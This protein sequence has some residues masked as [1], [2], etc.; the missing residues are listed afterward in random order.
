LSDLP[1][2]L[3]RASSLAKLPPR[4]RQNAANTWVR[5][6]G[7]AWSFSFA[8][9]D[10][11]W[12]ARERLND[13]PPGG[14]TSDEQLR[15]EQ[16]STWNLSL[17]AWAEWRRRPEQLGWLTMARLATE[18]PDPIHFA[19]AR[20]HAG[21][22]EDARDA[23]ARELVRQ[24]RSAREAIGMAEPPPVWGDAPPSRDGMLALDADGADFL[25][26]LGPEGKK[27]AEEL[28]TKGTRL[29]DDFTG[30]QARLPG[31]PTDPAALYHAWW[32]DKRWATSLPETPAG[33]L[34]QR[35]SRF[36]VALC[37]V[38]W[39]DVVP[40]TLETRSFAILRVTGL[41]GDD[42]VRVD[43]AAAAASWAFGGAAV[44]VDSDEYV[45]EPELV[46]RLMPRSW[47]FLPAAATQRP[48][49]YVLPL[50]SHESGSLLVAAVGAAAIARKDDGT[51][52]L[53]LPTLVGK[54]TVL[55][56]A[57]VRD[58][59]VVSVNLGELT[60][61][62]Y[63]AAKRLQPR[64]YARVTEA[65]LWTKSL[66]LVLPDDTAIQCFDIRAALSPKR[67][68][69]DQTVSWA[70]GRHL[71]DLT[72]RGTRG[73]SLRGYFVLNKSGAMPVNPKGVTLRG[74]GRTC[75]RPRRAGQGSRFGAT[76]RV[77]VAFVRIRGKK[78]MV[79]IRVM[80]RIQGSSWDPDHAWC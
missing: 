64:E 38:L 10:V 48:H 2:R 5:R 42:Y 44:T 78:I 32:P 31:V 45:A 15:L 13:L 35:P 50:E 77:L 51:R 41:D 63:P 1:W 3:E 4:K 26:R 46:T 66:H 56:L 21:E 43:K 17:L 70:I 53:T 57:S 19:L 55:V 23:L 14:R 54:L 79:V 30:V 67:A 52:L 49:Q 8:P 74:N 39:K 7:H 22:D 36:A 75:P 25:A 11:L 80:I 68:R 12:W 9:S 16:Y 18:D 28:R 34:E 29:W 69:P 40:R 37:E 58:D 6:Q 60:R 71:Q 24:L 62:L 76:S 47:E 61:E 59:E 20:Q 73:R 33:T 72:R 27:A 65:L